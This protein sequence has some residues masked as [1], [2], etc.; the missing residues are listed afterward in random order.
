MRLVPASQGGRYPVL[1]I[2]VGTAALRNVIR[3]GKTH[4]IDNII[5]TSSQMGMVSLESS[6]AG[7]VRSGKIT[8]ET[9]LSYS[10]KSEELMREVKKGEVKAK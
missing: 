5:Q 2:L 6:L 4:L 7:L 9:A 10:L 1:E 8:L 3:E